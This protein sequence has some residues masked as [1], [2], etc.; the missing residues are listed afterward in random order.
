MSA[1]RIFTPEN[2][3]ANILQSRNGPTTSEML[4]DA[5]QRVEA[6]QAS[7]ETFVA[8]KLNMI[9]PFAD[10][11]DDVLFAECRTLADTAT[12]IAEVAAAANLG[13]VGEISRGIVT[14]VDGLVVLGVWH[15]EAL[16]VHI[17][18]LKIV[19]QGQDQPVGEGDAIVESLRQMRMAVGL[20]D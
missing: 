17:R 14:M 10:Q 9:L 1:A 12:Q 19:T 15:S 16:R 8:G 13:A 20:K 2:R 18:A 7:I 4:A 5:T 11:N 6:L 3:L